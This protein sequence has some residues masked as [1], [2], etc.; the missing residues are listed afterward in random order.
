MSPLPL[1][2]VL[3]VA[4]PCVRGENTTPERRRT[5]KTDKRLEPLFFLGATHATEGL[6][7]PTK[8][9]ERENQATDKTDERPPRGNQPARERLRPLL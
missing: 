6:P 9:L 1:L 2:S 8:A 5:D 4:Y 7:K 3:S